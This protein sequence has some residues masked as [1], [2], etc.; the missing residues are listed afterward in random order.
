M[1]GFLRQHQLS[2]P[3]NLGRYPTERRLGLVIF[4]FVRPTWLIPVRRVPRSR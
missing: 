3:A 2:L 1:H 4:A